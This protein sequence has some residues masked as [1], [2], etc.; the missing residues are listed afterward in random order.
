MPQVPRYENTVVESQGVPQVRNPTEAPLES[1]GGGQSAQAAVKAGIDLADM[2]ARV[3]AYARQQADDARTKSAYLEMQDHVNKIQGEMIL[4]RGRAVV[5]KDM[6]GTYGEK[7]NQ[8]ASEIEK[9]FANDN[10]RAIWAGMRRKLEVEFNKDLNKHVGMET[11]KYNIELSKSGVQMAQQKAAQNFL[12]MG[13]VADALKEQELF[14]RSSPEALAKSEDQLKLDIMKARGETHQLVIQQ[15]L[16][17]DQDQKALGYYQLNKDDMDAETQI[18]MDKILDEQSLRGESQREMLKVVGK[19]GRNEKAAINYIEQNYG[20]NPKLQDALKDRVKGH[21]SEINT[22][23]NRMAE[24][25]MKKASD[26]VE[27]T[28]SIDEV[29]KQ[30]PAQ[31]AQFSTGQRSSL[32]SY[33]ENKGVPELSKTYYDLRK[34]AME[35]PKT[36]ANENLYNYKGKVANK[37]LEGLID[38]Q[39]SIRTGNSDKRIDDWRTEESIVDGALRKIGVDPNPKSKS[40]AERVAKFRSEV[41]KRI[42]DRIEQTQKKP[43]HDDYEEV[44]N[45]LTV[46]VV[47]KRGILWDTKKK[48]FELEI[49]DIPNDERVLIEGNLRERNKPITDSEILKWYKKGQGL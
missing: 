2:S 49:G 30:M 8:A 10:Q 24:D 40:D 42:N 19:F 14:I 31:W 12:D 41:A 33:A 1:F 47:T 43:S 11:E 5:E 4:D 26:I 18:K 32:K 28:G 17:N 20:S 25:W 21:Y 22:A 37:E 6:F 29:M 39:A 27:K 46:D 3:E 36:F 38:I 9:N 45:K 7:F 16:A 23:E 48:A 15:M 34:Q 44:V 13:K 35:N